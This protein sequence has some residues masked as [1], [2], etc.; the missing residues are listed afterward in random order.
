M[1]NVLLKMELNAPWEL[2]IKEPDLREGFSVNVPFLK[3]WSDPRDEKEL[4][5]VSGE[6]SGRGQHAW[7]P[8]GQLDPRNWKS[9]EST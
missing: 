5:K 9:E 2:K 4:T 3:T 8:G 1:I 6:R 7:N